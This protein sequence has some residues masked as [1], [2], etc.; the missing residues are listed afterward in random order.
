MSEAL[1]TPPPS[2][3]VVIPTLNAGPFIPLLADAFSAQEG[4]EPLEVILVDSGS[5][6]DTLS[7]AGAL[8]RWRVVPID[9][10]SHGRARNIGA[11][12][13]TG[14][15]VVLLSQDAIPAD[16]SWLSA[17]I[18]PFADSE[19]AATFS[20]QLPKPGANPMEQYFLRTHFPEG[21]PLRMQKRDHEPFSFQRGIF[22][23]NVSAAIRRATLLAHPFDE[24]IIMSEDQQFARD[25][26]NA[27]YAVVYTPHSRV[28]HSHNYTLNICFRRYFDSVYSL[29]QIFADHDC[30]SS[31][32]LGVRYVAGE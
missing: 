30:A 15:I 23:S 26:M 9:R 31:I 6:D 17:L 29:T 4:M 24:D 14:E 3:S 2:V 25:V 7:A 19:V 8:P 11:A 1:Q 28:L 21:A 12:E 22:F 16:P 27:G 5:K 18:K 20:R 13:A 32:S 10:F